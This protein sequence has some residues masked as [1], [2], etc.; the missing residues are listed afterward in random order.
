M[1]ARARSLGKNVKMLSLIRARVDLWPWKQIQSS[2]RLLAAI[3]RTT[4]VWR[5]PDLVSNA[6]RVRPQNAI[7]DKES[8][9]INGVPRRKKVGNLYR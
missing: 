7:L 8:E 6:R 3:A 5:G 1:W 2:Y 4:D 9:T